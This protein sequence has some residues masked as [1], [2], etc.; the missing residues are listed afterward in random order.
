[1]FNCRIS[2]SQYEEP[3]DLNPISVSNS[4]ADE[5]PEDIK[6]VKKYDWRDDNSKPEDIKPLK[7]K[8]RIVTIAAPPEEPKTAAPAAT[9]FVSVPKTTTNPK[10]AD[11]TAE[12]PPDAFEKMMDA[13]AAKQEAAQPA[14]PKAKPG[15]SGTT[16]PKTTSTPDGASAADGKNQAAAPTPQPPPPPF[17]PTSKMNK[18]E[19]GL[20]GPGKIKITGDL[21]LKLQNASASGD[22]IG[23]LSQNGLLYFNKS[24]Q[25]KT[26]LDVEGTMKNGLN[27]NGSFLEMPYQDRV[28]NIN[29]IGKR[30]SAKLGDTAAEFRVGPMAAF[31]KSIRGLDFKYDFGT[32][33]ITALVSRQKSKTERQAFYGQNIRGPYTLQSNSILDN[34][35]TISINGSPLSKS[36]YTMDYFLGQVTF[37]QNIDPTDLIEITYE[38]ELLVSQKTGSMNGFSIQSNPRRK[39]FDIGASY[40]E[41]G[42][43]VS[44]RDSVH[45]TMITFSGADISQNTAYLLGQKKLKKQSEIVSTVNASGTVLLARDS[46]YTIDYLMGSITFLSP[47][48]AADTVRIVYSYYDQKYMQ[49]IQNEELRDTGKGN[50]YQ[51]QNHTIYSGTEFVNLYTNDNL[52]RKLV[53]GTDYNVNEANNS[54]EFVNLNAQ[55]DNALKKYCVISYEIVPPNVPGA[56]TKRTLTDLTG[57]VTLGPAIFRAELSETQSDVSFKTIQVLEER[58][59]TVGSVTDGVFHLQFKAVNNTEEI[60]FNDMVSPNSRQIQGSDYVLDYDAAADQT[61]LRFKKPI[62]L[63]TTILANYKYS[64]MVSGTSRSGRAGRITADV[65]IPRG[66]LQGEY[67]RKS[68]FY[69]PATQYNDLETDRLGLK[70]RVSPFKRMM[71]GASYLGRKQ[72]AGFSSNTTFN[73]NEFTGQT[74][75]SFGRGRR[76]GYSFTKRTRTDNLAPRNSDTTQTTQRV[77]GYYPVGDGKIVALDFHGET[78]G[79]TDATQKTSDFKVFKGGFGV[80]YTPAENLHLKLSTDNNRVRSK[81]PASIGAPGDFTTKTLSNIFDVSY[82]PSKVWT[83]TAKLDSQSLADSRESVGGSRLDNMI[84]S[85]IAKPGGRIKV[86]SADFNKQNTPNQYYGNSLVEAISSHLDYGISR[87]WVLTPSFMYSDSGVINRNS[88]LSRN[89]GLRAQFRPSALKGLIASLQY[90]QN[91]RT[92]KQPVTTAA[93]SWNSTKNNENKIEL[94]TRFIPSGRMELR[95]NYV[96]TK[97]KYVGRAD[98]RSTITSSVSYVYSPSTTLAFTVHKE[99]APAGSPGRMMYQL[100]SSTRLDQFFSLGASFKKEKQSGSSLPYDGTLFNM[101]LS[102]EF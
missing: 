69:S 40:L 76:L 9:A 62:P 6:P 79:I 3:E 51:L 72:G 94:L 21:E 36:Q 24:F 54:I 43:G 11:A 32:V 44:T 50:S 100:D 13:E 18:S 31:S 70:I 83:L 8:R 47:V 28:F 19:N 85:V 10:P 71:A 82:L 89:A 25:Q 96:L 67:M 22:K 74:E 39:L 16:A 33:S 29:L 48:A 38:S 81:A 75:Y 1:M 101:S 7:T 77:E 61:L 63:G 97:D 52:E 20:A 60:Y 88:S 73:T 56:G 53:P 35:E 65:T 34:S 90:N 26:R 68:F 78:G 17:P 23:F 15:A 86:F 45:E 84:A 27:V 14:A 37:N 49:F 4:I 30:G 87:D 102:A 55:P 59:A 2:F 64:P 92:D 66:T 57:R 46:N 42:A 80:T 58:V 99:T 93:A 95:N 91:R 41:E 12:E 98:Q 5:K